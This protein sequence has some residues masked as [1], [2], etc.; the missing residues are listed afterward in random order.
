M[1]DDQVLR[2]AGKHVGKSSVDGF[3][4]GGDVLAR[5]HLDAE[6]DGAGPFPLARRIPFEM[7]GEVTGRVLVGARGINQVAQI[8]RRSRGSDRYHHVAQFALAREF[9]GGIDGDAFP[10]DIELPSGKSYIAGVQYGR[11]RI[12]FEPIGCEALLRVCKVNALLKLSGAQDFG[13]QRG[14]VRRARGSQ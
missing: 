4:E 1:L 11:E 13:Y 6:S 5:P 10:R 2:K 9:S 3:I 8:N 7:E 14:I 12:W